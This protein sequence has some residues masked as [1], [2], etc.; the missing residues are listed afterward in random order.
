M[1]GIEVDRN[2]VLT[3]GRE[4][5]GKLLVELQVR[6]STADGSGA[7][8]FYTELTRPMPG[9]EGQI[10]KLVLKKK[11]VRVFVRHRKSP[12][13]ENVLGW[14]PRK[15]F[16]QPNTFIVDDEARLKE[17]PLTCAG[18]IESFIERKL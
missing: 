4:V 11:Q 12:L 18:V 6:K 17:Y 16:V 7:R 1:N 3:K 13:D 2:L 5:T 9:W 14:Q 8:E 10:S 15:I